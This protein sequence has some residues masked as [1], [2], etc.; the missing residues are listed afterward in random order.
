[1]D[2]PAPLPWPDLRDPRAFDELHDNPVRWL[3]WVQGLAR[4][5]GLP[6]GVLPLGEGTALVVQVGADWIL[7][8]FPPFLRDHWAFERG[9]LI[10]LQGQLTVPT[11]RLE[12]SGDVQGW[13]WLLMN[14]LE[15][16][17]LT[18]LW[19][20]LDEAR[21]HGLL[22]Q[23][24]ELARQ[25]HGVP[26]G[27]QQTLAPL[28]ADFLARQRTGCWARQQRT[29]LPPQL[30]AQVEAF[31]AGP[32]PLD[33]KVLLTGEFTPMNLMVDPQ[34]ERVIG[35]FD[36][37][38]GLIGPCAYDWGGPLA[39][40]AAGHG[41]RVAAFFAGYGVAFDEAARTVQ[42]RLLLLHR[43]SHLP[44]QLAGCPGWADTPTLPALARHLWPI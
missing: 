9:L 5:L 40:L 43:Y 10:R 42:L 8:V 27:D 26:V 34:G 14:R 33:P 13:P 22:R 7:K 15:G 12:A 38:D 21:R 3:T 31:V 11:P 29:G 25:V 19:P 37:G 24:G 23:I 32:V 20:R 2:T 41:E 39:F 1:M 36:F 44:I 28:W 16:Q 17:T 4:Q 30:L 35:L 6:E 18:A